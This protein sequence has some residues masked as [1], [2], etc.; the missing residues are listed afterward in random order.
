MK[1]DNVEKE[2]VV[3]VN[4][5]GRKPDTWPFIYSLVIGKNY[6]ITKTQILCLVNKDV[7]IYS[8]GR[9]IQ[10]YSLTK[11]SEM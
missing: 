6:Q 4:I 3:A 2:A 9:N 8:L 7:Q 1:P 5:E 10:D 11:H